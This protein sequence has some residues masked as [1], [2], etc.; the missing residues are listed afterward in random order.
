MNPDVTDIIDLILYRLPPGRTLFTK[1][2]I[3]NLL[4]D[5]RNENS[6]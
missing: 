2:E 5:L 4:L 1:D 3:V 6:Q